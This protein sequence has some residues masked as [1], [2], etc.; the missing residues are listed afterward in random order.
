MPQNWR[1]VKVFISS[2]FRDMQAERDHL[3]RFVFPRLRE[4][5]LKRRIHLVDVDLRWGVT[6]EQNVLE[7]C[8]QII[9]ECRPRFLCILG[10]RYGWTPPGREESITAQ[11]IRYAVLHRPDVN[12]YRFFYFRDPD[13]TASIPEAAAKAGGY[14]EFPM[15]DE[16]AEYGP[17]EAKARTQR[18]SEKLE[19]L[20]QEIRDAGYGPFIYPARWDESQQRLVD[21]KAFG[22][23]VYA[24]LLWSIDDEFGPDAPQELDEFAAESAAIEAFIQERVERYVAG[25][26]QNLLQELTAFVEGKGP[27]NVLVISGEPGSGKSALLGKFYLDYINTAKKP[28]HPQDL[29]I[30]HFI[31]ASPGSTDLRRSLRRFCHELAQAAGLEEEIPQD[32][33]ELVRKFPDL[34]KRAAAGRRVVL[35]IDALNQMDAAGNAH[36]MYWLPNNI[37]AHV[38]IIV[39]SLER[40]TEHPTLTTL[41]RRGNERVREEELNPLGA[42]DRRAI[43]TGF[44]NRYRKRMT[45]EQI[46]TLLGKEESGNPLYLLTVLEE[47]RTL[48]TYEEITK[49]IKDLPGQVP[50][51][52]Q[53]I[54]RRLEDDPG[55]QD[56]EGRPIGKNLVRGFASLLGASRYGLSQLELA[57]LLAPGAPQAHPPI[58]P[59]SQGNVAALLG[60]LRPYLMRRGELLDF[61]HGQ[62]QQAAQVAY[63][64]QDEPR[65]AAHSYL[66]DYFKRQADPGHTF[67]WEW[68]ARWLAE[69]AFHLA[70][71]Q[72]HLELQGLLSQLSYLGGRVATGQVY[73]LVADYSLAG[74]PLPPAL[75]LWRDFLQKH[76]QRLAR[77]RAMLLAL[78]HHEG[79]PE[80][81]AQA[82][83]TPWRQSWLSTAPEQMPPGQAEVPAEGL[84]AEVI[85]E[86]NFHQEWVSAIAPQRA[87]GFCVE[88]L[89]ALGVLDLEAMRQTDTILAIR[90]ERP[91]VLA[92][93]PDAG[94][95]A[96]FY[97]TGE[98]ELYRVLWGTDG[99]PARLELL[100]EF[101]FYLPECEDP[102][103]AWHQGACWFQTRDDALAWVS[104]A[105]P[106]VS[107]EL[108]PSGHTGELAALLFNEGQ[109]LV[110][111]RQGRD[112]SL[113]TPGAPPLQRLGADVIAACA[114]GEGKI[115]IAFSDGALVIYENANGLKLQNEL[116][117]G[118]LLGALGWD[119]SRLLWLAPENKFHA[120][121]PGDGSTSLV[122]D[123]QKVFPGLLYVMPRS[124]LRRNDGSML[125]GT[126][127]GVVAFTLHEGERAAEG[128][129]ESFL[130]GPVWRIVVKRETD[131]WLLES[132]PRRQ[133]LIARGIQGHLYCAPD[134]TGHFFA[135]SGY[136]P[137][138][139][140]DLTTLQTTPIQGCPPGL[141]A[142]VGD[143]DGGCWLT[144]RAGDIYFVNVRGVC[145][146]IERIG[147]SDVRGAQLK[148]CGSYLVWHGY[149]TEFFPETGAEGARTFVFFRK[150][151]GMRPQLEHLGKQFRHPREGQCIALCADKRQQL[152]TLWEK[153]SGGGSYLLR[154]GPV[155]GFIDWHFQEDLVTGLGDIGFLQAELSADA[156]LLGIVTRAGEFYCVNIADGRVL[157]SLAGSAPFTAVAPG[158]SGPEFWLVEAGSRVYRGSLMRQ[159]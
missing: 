49:R 110:A 107:E 103:A 60:L 64:V 146:L 150:H 37:P 21:L 121:H 89:G 68:N 62:L 101:R 40:P 44:L 113:L 93:A 25:S 147:L 81:R 17:E 118:V 65:Q 33:Q 45:P 38:R 22:D 138:F 28:T 27:P 36:A 61:F 158:A 96:V 3:V 63:F 85:G 53:W 56:E 91:L 109:R 140:F 39:S 159:S 11:E 55:F 136:G 58:P 97:E 6:S 14:Q 73:E 41:R 12:E 69:L 71:A 125:V 57:D 31:G 98:A 130:G 76:A 79:F 47:L 141:N 16:E 122:H 143:P 95:L 131:Q 149:S 123:N 144:D 83:T 77:H 111:L 115:A 135:A 156:K 124:W 29:V 104:P 20:K 48:G 154:V 7:V 26:R 30:P 105:A 24:D 5:L 88:R 100:V 75:V 67:N 70:G 74:S 84:G 15:P 78:A 80:A 114:C 148:I 35:L 120:W 59:D 133:M 126:T 137:G 132:Q 13:V 1:T 8:T 117:V 152:V 42:E 19:S 108:L 139:M 52:F 50:G 102:V 66:A 94:A 10:G 9:D 145:Q 4:E 82:E 43:I 112:T 153:E 92:C 86:I 134:G 157:A 51:L 18:R 34:L 23:Q 106:K 142:A 2:T 119:G 90:R 129:F 72:R 127:H 46:V 151:Q 128:R 99:W 32:L 87:I 155:T 116:H 54:F